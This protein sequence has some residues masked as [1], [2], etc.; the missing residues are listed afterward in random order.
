[1]S[2]CHVLLSLMHNSIACTLLVWICIPPIYSYRVTRNKLNNVLT[3]NT[4]CTI[5]YFSLGLAFVCPHV[6]FLMNNMWVE[7]THYNYWHCHIFCQ[8][9]AAMWNSLLSIIVC[10]N[11]PKS[12]LWIQGCISHCLFPLKHG[13]TL[14]WILF[15]DFF[16]L[17]AV[18]ILYV[19]SL[20]FSKMTHCISWKTTT[21]FVNVSILF[22]KKYIGFIGLLSS[23]ISD[24]VTH[25]SLDNFG[26]LSERYYGKP[27]LL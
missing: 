3:T 27:W 19:W 21:Y 20:R 26:D 4:T 5:V 23:I 14:T 13:L 15:W 12:K 6:S 11:K 7:I 16:V 18:M 17:N 2:L 22:F 24:R 9:N 8:H 25:A 1:M 10:V